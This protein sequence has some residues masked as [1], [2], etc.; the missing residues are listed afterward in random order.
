[1]TIRN[2]VKEHMTDDNNQ[3]PVSMNFRYP[4]IIKKGNL[5]KNCFKVNPL[6]SLVIYCFECH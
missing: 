1:M 3:V 5:Q 6:F 4:C 2:E